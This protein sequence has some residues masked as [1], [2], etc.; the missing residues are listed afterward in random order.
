VTLF[1]FLCEAAISGLIIRLMRLFEWRVKGPE[2]RAERQK[3][4]AV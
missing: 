2:K 1:F 3:G 4:E